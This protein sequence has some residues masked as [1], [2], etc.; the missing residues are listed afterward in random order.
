MSRDLERLREFERWIAIVRVLAVP[1]AIFQVALGSGYPPGYES[2]AWI[3]T[4]FFGLGT[5]V[6]FFAS[7]QP[8]SLELT[9]LVGAGALLFDTLVLGTYVVVYSFENG[10]PIRQVLYLAVVEAALRYRLLGALVI[11]VLS[12]PILIAFEHLREH[13]VSPRHFRLDFVTLQLGS[14]LILGAIV[15][16]IVSAILVPMFTMINAINN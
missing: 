4:A 8:L 14:M 1:F 5:I 12:I 6:L 11:S 9:R 2:A 3:T 10:S 15:G 7:R 16:F 13:Y